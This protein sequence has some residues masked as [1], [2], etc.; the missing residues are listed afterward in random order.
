MNPQRIV[1][2]IR[3]LCTSLVVGVAV[4]SVAS[5]AADFADDFNAGPPDTGWN[6]FDLSVAGLPGG[7][8]G[9]YTFPPANGGFAYRIDSFANPDPGNFGPGRAFSYRS[10]EYSRAVISVDV[11]DWTTVPDVAFGIL[12]RANNIGPGSTEGYVFNYNALDENLQ[13]NPI[14]GEAAG[15]T[16]AQTPVMLDPV[17]FDYRWELSMWGP[18]LVGRVFQLPDTKNP[19]ASVVATDET[20]AAGQAGLFNFDR[21]GASAAN[22][23]VAS[24]TFDNYAVAVPSEGSLAAVA[25]ELY[26]PPGS[27]IHETRPTFKAAILNRETTVKADSFTLSVD[28]EAISPGSLSISPDVMVPNNSVA[29]PGATMT[30]I[31]AAGLSAGSHTLAVAFTDSTEARY[32]NTWSFVSDYLQNPSTPGPVRGFN[33]RLTQAAQQGGGLG[34]SLQRAVVQLAPDSP[35]EALYSTNVVAD[36]INY[37]QKAINPE[38]GTDGNF[39]DDQPF[40]GQTPDGPTDNYAME[41]TCWLDLPQGTTTFGVISDDGFQVNSPALTVNPIVGRHNGGPADAEFSVYAAQAGLYPFK[42]IWYENTGGAHLEWFV[43]D[44]EFRFLLNTPGAPAAYTSAGI[45]TPTITLLSAPTLTGDYTDAGSYVVD[46]DNHTITLNAPA[47]GTT[48]YRVSAAV[49]PVTIEQ[50]NVIGNQIIIRYQ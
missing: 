44:G 16:I 30:Y 19:V 37:S 14:A 9:T 40:P 28:G 31:P 26:P 39:A 18:N 36:V 32:T 13:L 2:P 1:L 29:F 5:V 23:L 17:R 38:L 4:C 7:P 43:Y 6:H 47:A 24:T 49:G 27:G 42:L 10:D 11:L 41:V 3:R 21:D 15:D 22:V 48:F 33:V 25:V 20:T 46:S 35:I 12:F 8:Y 45:V 34:N 50:I